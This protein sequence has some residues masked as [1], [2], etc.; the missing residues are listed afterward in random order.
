MGLLMLVSVYL[1]FSTV[2]L[3]ITSFR[4]G[5][6]T[7]LKTLMSFRNIDYCGIS[8]K[9]NNPRLAHFLQPGAFYFTLTEK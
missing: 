1:G 4:K 6:H 3:K 9:E 5:S 7:F 8:F 2:H